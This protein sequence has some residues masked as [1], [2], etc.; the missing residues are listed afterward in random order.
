M[1][2]LIFILNKTEKL[3]RLLKELANAHLTGA[4]V[5]NSSGMASQL[6]RTND[7]S[8]SNIFGSLR[9][10]LKDNQRENKTIMMVVKE[11]RIPDIEAI[12]NQVVGNITEPN[13]GILFTV[14]IDFIRGYKQ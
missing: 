8:L 14:P 5:F 13:T 1:K 10:L 2:L 11:E 7:E 3:D 9:H 4:T 6:S 12:I